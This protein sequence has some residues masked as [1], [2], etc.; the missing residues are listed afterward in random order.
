MPEATDR[1]LVGARAGRPVA[2]DRA[3]RLGRRRR[4]RRRAR[5]AV[6]AGRSSRLHLTMAWLATALAVAGG[7]FG[8]PRAESAVDDLTAKQLA[9]QR[10]VTGFAGQTPPRDLLRRI[11]R[12]YVGGVILFAHNVAEPAA[13]RAHGRPAP[14]R[15][16]SARAE[17]AAARDGGPGGWPGAADPGR[18][19]ELGR[20]HRRDRTR[21]CGAPS[22]TSRG[23]QPAHGARERR[24]RAGR[25]RGAAGQRDG[26]RAARVRPPP[27]QG[28]ALRHRVRVRR[29]AHGCPRHRQA[30]PRL[31]RCA[32]EHRQRAGHD[33]H[34]AE[35]PAAPS[36]SVP[37]PRCSAA[38][39]GW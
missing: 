10:V 16:P 2:R 8:V 38:A 27:R 11:R 17:A 5:A 30:L 34:A 12:G 23:A 29:A 13:G 9:G 22:G 3:L 28:R 35:A 24:P 33:Q 31:R 1:L 21:A 14:V 39:S 7:G 19:R 36:T 18:A 26:A 20:G 4:A 32:R 15:A 6:P 25:R 37:T